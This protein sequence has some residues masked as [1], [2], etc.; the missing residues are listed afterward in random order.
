MISDNQVMQMIDALF[1]FL[2]S[3]YVLP[4][5]SLLKMILMFIATWVVGDVIGF[6]RSL[7]KE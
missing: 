1:D 5:I 3:F 2:A 7:A 4:G 6:F